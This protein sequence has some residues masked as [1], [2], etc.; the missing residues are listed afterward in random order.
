MLTV[1]LISITVS[2][3]LFLVVHFKA[4]FMRMKCT[5]L[6]LTGSENNLFVEHILRLVGSHVL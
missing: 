5:D 2:K 3:I 1:V 4:V 6:R